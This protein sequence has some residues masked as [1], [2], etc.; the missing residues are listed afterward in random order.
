MYDNHPTE[1]NRNGPRPKYLL[2]A[3]RRREQVHWLWRTTDDAVF[4]IDEPDRLERLTLAGDRSPETL[5][6]RIADE[7]GVTRKCL[8]GSF[9]EALAGAI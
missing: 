5:V 2:L 3:V 9:A 1:F 4:V 8:A 6:A 7:R